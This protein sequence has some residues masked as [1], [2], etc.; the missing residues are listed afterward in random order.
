MWIHAGLQVS[1]HRNQFAVGDV[2]TITCSFDLDLTS[3]EWL[4]SGAIVARTTAPQLSLTFNPV[5]DTIN[6]RQYT[7]RVAT[8]YGTQEETIAIG[9]QGSMTEV[10]GHSL[11]NGDA[12]FDPLLLIT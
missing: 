2:A 12:C 1:G 6:N 7:C 10:N 3:I 11:E 9:V 5:N 4:Y 8:S